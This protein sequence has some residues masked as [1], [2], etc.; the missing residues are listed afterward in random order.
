[1]PQ[2]CRRLRRLCRKHSN[3]VA[4]HDE[5]PVK[6]TL[7]SRDKNVSRDMSFMLRRSDIVLWFFIHLEAAVHALSVGLLLQCCDIRHNFF[8]RP[9]YYKTLILWNS[10]IYAILKPWKWRL[11]PSQSSQRI[12]VC[13]WY[14]PYKRRSYLMIFGS[15]HWETAKLGPQRITVKSSYVG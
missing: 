2:T 4:R 12:L 8:C 11:K 1:M 13:G 9:V 7:L 15:K 5:T 10:L 3:N 6:S 14:P